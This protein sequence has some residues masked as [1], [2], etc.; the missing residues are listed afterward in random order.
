VLFKAGCNEQVFYPKFSKKLAQIRHVVFEKNTKTAHF[1][2][3][4]TSPNRRLGY[5]NNQL[6]VNRL[7][8]GFR[9][10]HL[11]I[12]TCIE[13]HC[14]RP[15][16]SLKLTL[17]RSLVDFQT[18]RF[19]AHCRDQTRP[20]WLA[21]LNPADNPLLNDSTTHINDCCNH[22]SARGRATS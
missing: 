22:L 20:M 11:V 3:K 13:K 18:L 17:W 7:I 8:S 12:T 2:P 21:T 10:K 16:N 1:I 9:K 15:L 4:M 6:T 5:S 19:L 14:T